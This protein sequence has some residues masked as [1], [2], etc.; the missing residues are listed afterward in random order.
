MSKSVLPSKGGFSPCQEMQRRSFLR[1]GKFSCI[2][3]IRNLD[4]SSD[5]FEKLLLRAAAAAAVL[6]DGE[7]GLFLFFSVGF[8]FSVFS[9]RWSVV[10]GVFADADAVP[11]PMPM[12]M[13]PPPP[14]LLPL[15]ET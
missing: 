12:P 14:T 1:Y 10:A 4:S 13:P 6:G 9:P 2:N 11:M 3:P 7:L 8:G 5:S 15:A